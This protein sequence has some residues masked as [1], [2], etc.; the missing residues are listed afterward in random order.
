MPDI[1][2]Q[3]FK[4]AFGLPPEKAIEYLTR[5]GFV[6]GYKWQD[7]WK[8]THNRAFTVAKVMKIDILQLIFDAMKTAQAEGR[9]FDKFQRTLEPV[10]KLAGWWGREWPENAGGLKV[11]PDGQPFPV[12]PESGE[13]M[14][15]KDKRPPLLG[16]PSRLKTIYYTNMMVSYSAG[17]EAAFEQSSLPYAQYI[18]IIDGRTTPLCNRLHGMVLPVDDPFWDVFTPPNHWRCR[19]RKRLLTAGKV[20]RLGLTVITSEGKLGSREVVVNQKTGEKRTA[21]TFT[22]GD[23][24]FMTGA[25]WDYRPGK[26]QFAPDLAKY[27]PA[28]QKQF[29]QDKQQ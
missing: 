6:L 24:T 17:R 25:G 10:L 13:Q 11:G 8:E 23:D 1:S 14:L 26:T 7:V 15:P 12:D 9:T 21:G 16:S 19:A 29:K 22:L 20:K 27:D 5:K 4:V 28:L 18:D 3:I 2:P